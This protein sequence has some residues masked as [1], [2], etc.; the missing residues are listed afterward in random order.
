MPMPLQ[1]H[2][3][4]IASVTGLCAACIKHPI[5]LQCT[6]AQ[7]AGAPTLLLW[8]AGREAR[9]HHPAHKHGLRMRRV[10]Q[11]QGLGLL[12]QQRQSSAKVVLDC[13]RRVA[14]QRLGYGRALGAGKTGRYFAS[15]THGCGGWVRTSEN[16]SGHCQTLP[17]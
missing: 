17:Y 9:A 11:V 6:L 15:T 13:T 3:H 5:K 8:A 16:S 2:S 14:K 7:P 1:G 4:S 12:I 10:R